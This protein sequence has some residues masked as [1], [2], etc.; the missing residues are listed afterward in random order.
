MGR[1]A[2]RLWDRSWWVFS[3]ETD[4][5]RIVME[6]KQTGSRVVWTV[7]LGLM[8]VG[9]VRPVAAEEPVLARLSFW[10]PSE[11]M[12]QFEAAYE[13]LVPVLKKHGLVETSLRGRATVDS[14]FSRLF[15][16]QVPKQVR[17]IALKLDADPQW[18]QALRRVAA[19]DTTL[20]HHLRIYRRL[21]ALQCR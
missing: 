7:A 17:I 9:L 1:L 18:Q 20:R 3:V 13:E 6:R 21:C 8:L 15:A 4:M 5:S 14:I 10:V 16:V 12:D 19:P 2:H 11:R